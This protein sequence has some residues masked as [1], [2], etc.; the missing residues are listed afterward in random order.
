M[1]HFGRAERVLI[2]SNILLA[3]ALFRLNA[4]QAQTTG[5]Q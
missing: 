5:A 4:V 1:A 3:P 2:E